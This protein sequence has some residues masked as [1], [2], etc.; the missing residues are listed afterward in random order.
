MIIGRL[1]YPDNKSENPKNNSLDIYNVDFWKDGKSVYFNA[2]GEPSITLNNN[3]FV[4]PNL[5]PGKYY[6][7][8]F[9]AGKNYYKLP[10][11]DDK[12]MVEV[13][14]GQIVYYGSIDYIDGREPGW[15]REGTYSLRKVA[16]PSEREMLQWFYQYSDGTGWDLIIK[17]RLQALGEHV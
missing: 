17:K 14:P 4:V 15:F 10:R 11:F 16:K 3:Y 9:K 5:Q 6:F 13:K 12:Y 7:V 1:D 8:G 2:N